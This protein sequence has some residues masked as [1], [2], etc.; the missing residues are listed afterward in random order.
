MDAATS[1]Y[2]LRV[3][4]LV[5]END[6]IGFTAFSSSTI[7]FL[8]LGAGGATAGIYRIISDD[9]NITFV[10]IGNEFIDTRFFPLITAVISRKYSLNLNYIVS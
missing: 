1:V 5:K 8:D 6:I 7:R 9:T 2:S 10:D 4:L 3:N